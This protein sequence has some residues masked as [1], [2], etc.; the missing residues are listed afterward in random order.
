MPR[1]D[2]FSKIK[3]T[4][5][6]SE[7][8]SGLIKAIDEFLLE[9][10]ELGFPYFTEIDGLFNEFGDLPL[11]YVQKSKKLRARIF[12][13]I[14]KFRGNLLCFNTPELLDSMFF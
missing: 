14:E 9:D 11:D 13:A 7:Q 4:L 1:D 3:Q 8:R 6:E 5:F 12:D 2:R 10:I